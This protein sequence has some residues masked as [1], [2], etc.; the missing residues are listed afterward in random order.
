MANIGQSS[1]SGIAKQGTAPVGIDDDDW[2]LEDDGAGT[3]G[4]AQNS[5][6]VQ[7]RISYVPPTQMTKA[8]TSMPNRTNN[9]D[10][11]DDLLDD[12]GVGQSAQV[13]A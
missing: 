7:R 13:G 1:M 8:V 2:D 10:D 6:H 4:A 9:L 3:G 11:F 5:A 12:F